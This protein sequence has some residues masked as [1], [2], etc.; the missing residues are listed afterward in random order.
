METTC[1]WWTP[2]ASAQVIEPSY[3]REP[4]VPLGN[5]KWS[6]SVR[7]GWRNG[8][9]RSPGPVRHVVTRNAYNL[10]IHRH[11]HHVSS[12]VIA[13]PVVQGLFRPRTAELLQRRT[14][15]FYRRRGQL[16]AG[17]AAPGLDPSPPPCTEHVVSM[18][19]TASPPQERR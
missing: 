9:R 1:P 15:S 11:T 6:L 13:L 19:S 2:P 10:S 4:M 3:Y 5:T 7:L 17:P 12:V 14:R 8:P 18:H 16:C